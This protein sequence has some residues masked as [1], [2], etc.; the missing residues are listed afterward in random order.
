MLNHRTVFVTNPQ[1]LHMRVCSEIVRRL[2]RYRARVTVRKGDQA[3]D[4]ASILGLMTLAAECGTKL[5]LFATGPEAE[6]ALQAICLLLGDGN[7]TP[8]NRSDGAPLD[9]VIGNRM[10]NRGSA[11]SSR[12]GYTHGSGRSVHDVGLGKS[13]AIGQDGC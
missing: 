6:E 13:A 3:E 4:A 11:A 1:G 12:L 5:V 8:S 10:R 9:C 7:D 2:Q